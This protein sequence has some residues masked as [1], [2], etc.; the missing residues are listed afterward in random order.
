MSA[1]VFAD[2][3]PNR[4]EPPRW[5]VVKAEPCGWVLAEEADCQADPCSGCLGDGSRLDVSSAI[6]VERQTAI[7]GMAGVPCAVFV[8]TE[9][10]S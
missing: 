6:P 9:A 2:G 7:D 4:T 5:F 8:P 10:D 3:E 1:D